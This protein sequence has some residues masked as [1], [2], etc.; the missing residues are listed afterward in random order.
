MQG[1]SQG[2]TFLPTSPQPLNSILA[3]ASICAFRS[4]TLTKIQQGLGQ[5]GRHVKQPCVFWQGSDPEA[6]SAR[7]RALLRLAR[8]RLW[9]HVPHHLPQIPLLACMH[10]VA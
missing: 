1:T 3:R 7:G 8:R 4:L 9:P 10:P 6:W 2:V 5:G